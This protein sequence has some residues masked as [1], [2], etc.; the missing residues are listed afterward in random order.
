MCASLYEKNQALIVTKDANLTSF[1]KIRYSLN[2][3]ILYTIMSMILSYC[4]V[5]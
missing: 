5:K 1:V 4:L 3:G 2:Y